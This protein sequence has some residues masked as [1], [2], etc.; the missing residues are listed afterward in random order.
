MAS[1]IV[2]KW[3]A[4]EFSALAPAL[5]DLHLHGGKLVGDVQIELGD[6]IGGF[7][8]RRLSRKLNLP[9]PGLHQ[10]VVTITH[11]T[12]ALHWDRRFNDSIEMNSTFLPVGF[13]GSGYWIERTGPLQMKLTVD[14]KNGGWYWRCLGFSVV[15]VPLPAWIFPESQA[16]KYVENDCYRFYVGF[17]APLIGLLVSYGGLLKK[18]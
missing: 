14:V 15:G 8:G 2:K 7:L 11:S 6:G 13:I 9:G 4:A 18:I 1:E 5:Q 12:E 16:Y 17:K 10:L 3:F